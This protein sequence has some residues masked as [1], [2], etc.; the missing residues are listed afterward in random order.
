MSAAVKEA[1][2]LPSPH[3]LATAEA[4]AIPGDAWK[5]HK[6]IRVDSALSLTHSAVPARSFGL[7]E[8]ATADR[9]VERGLARPETDRERPDRDR[10]RASALRRRG[11]EAEGQAD[12][13]P[14]GQAQA[15]ERRRGWRILTTS[16][17]SR[18]LRKYLKL[19][20]ADDDG[21]ISRHRAS[22][23]ALVE[24]HTA[25]NLLDR[26]VA[27]ESPGGVR[28]DLVFWVADAKSTASQTVDFRRPEDGPGFRATA[29]V[30]VPAD[31][32]RILDDRII[33]RPDEGGWPE[34]R[35]GTFYAA[36]VAAGMAADAVPAELKEAVALIVREYYEGSGM[37]ELPPGGVIAAMVGPFSK[38]AAVSPAVY[39]AI[40]T[41]Q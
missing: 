6:V 39:A 2:P 19:S 17:P 37:D 27:A 3:S 38:T 13:G 18:K 26:D 21:Q 1:Y 33:L 23:V 12:P 24:K 9:L 36:T 14:E 11:L 25:R 7:V 8:A 34:R 10:Q 20:T 28:D 40:E 30:S 35:A 29:G 41:G 32:R 16:R 5:S 15:G 4:A 31:R 22:A